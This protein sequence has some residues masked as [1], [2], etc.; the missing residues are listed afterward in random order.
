[1][2]YWDSSGLVA[3]IVSQRA[4]NDVRSLLSED[5]VLLCWLLSDVEV[6]SALARLDRERA[7]DRDDLDRA[8]ARFDSLWTGANLI[9]SVDAVKI[10]ARRLLRTHPLTAADALQLG[11]AL[12]AAHDDPRSFEVVCLDDRLREAARREGFA[13][14]P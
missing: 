1:V 9:V 3:L 4:T 12:T 8:S 13:V 11:A 10:R 2:R 5:P 6:S 14:R 7:M